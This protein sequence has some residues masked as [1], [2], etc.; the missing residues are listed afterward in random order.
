MHFQQPVCQST[1]LHRAVHG[2]SEQLVNDLLQA[3]ASTSAHQGEEHLRTPLHI[4]ADK[5]Y[6]GIVSSLLR[7]GVDVDVLEAF[8]ISA[9]IRAAKGGHPAVVETQLTAGAVVSIE[10]GVLEFERLR[11]SALRLR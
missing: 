2:G 11:R 3:G 1:P 10:G 6:D 4:A 8:G 9:L 5:G 7:S